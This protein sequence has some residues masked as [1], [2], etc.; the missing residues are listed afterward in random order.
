VYPGS[1]RADHALSAKATPDTGDYFK[2]NWLK[3]YQDPELKR[4]AYRELHEQI[5][6]DVWT[7]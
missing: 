5:G 2:A 6:D 1:T 3:P 7:L 4:D